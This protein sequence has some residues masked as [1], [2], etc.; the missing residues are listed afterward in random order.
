[1]EG[2][3]GRL[4]LT[5]FCSRADRGDVHVFETMRAEHRIAFMPCKLRQGGT[6]GLTTFVKIGV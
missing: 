3:R 4:D 1:M 5:G 6:F 2:G